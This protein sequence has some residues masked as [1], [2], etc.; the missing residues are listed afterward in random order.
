VHARTKALFR[1]E[2]VE[3]ALLSINRSAVKFFSIISDWSCSIKLSGV[4]DVAVS[5]FFLK[6]LFLLEYQP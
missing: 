6:P 5:E 4:G 3:A 2:A 1:E